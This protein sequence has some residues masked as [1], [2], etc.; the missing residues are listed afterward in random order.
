VCGACLVALHTHHVAAC[1]RRRLRL[2]CHVPLLRP[3]YQHRALR[4]RIPPVLFP[5]VPPPTTTM[6]VS[7]YGFF[8]GR[9]AGTTS[10][11]VVVIPRRRLIDPRPHPHVHCRAPPG[12]V[13]NAADGIDCAPLS[14]PVVE[15]L[16]S[17][18]IRLGSAVEHDAGGLHAGQ[19][20]ERDVSV[21]VLFQSHL[22]SNLVVNVSDTASEFEHN[23]SPFPPL[24]TAP[25]SIAPSFNRTPVLSA[26]ALRRAG[27]EAEMG[28]ISPSATAVL[29]LP[30]LHPPRAALLL[31]PA[32]APVFGAPQVSR[33]CG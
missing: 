11:H 20:A 22:I 33:T 23:G 15:Y 1:C 26:L 13:A 17:A 30:P 8:R 28:G 25:H 29:K 12:V 2:G 6:I 10:H 24:N 18:P 27:W 5:P 9:R 7:N 14:L 31:H 32:R 21:P 4:P 19:G 16:D 3:I